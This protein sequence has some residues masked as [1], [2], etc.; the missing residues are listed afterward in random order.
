MVV[1]NTWGLLVCQQQKMTACCGAANGYPVSSIL[2]PR[3]NSYVLRSTLRGASQCPCSDKTRRAVPYPSRTMTEGFQLIRTAVLGAWSLD[4]EYLVPTTYSY[5][6]LIQ[7]V[8]MTHHRTPHTR[9]CAC[10]ID[11][12]TTYDV[13]AQNWFSSSGA[14]FRFQML[15]PRSKNLFHHG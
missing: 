9:P 3:R 1:K 11:P 8:M 4:H 12:L 7:S 13:I 14:G 10:R 15:F 6:R 2:Y 5:G